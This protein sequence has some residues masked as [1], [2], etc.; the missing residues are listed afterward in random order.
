M[1]VIQIRGVSDGAHRRLKEM[2][3]GEGLSLT[4]FLR[5]ELEEMARAMTPSEWSEWVA[6]REPVTG[7]S[8]AEL[9]RQAREE[10][11]RYLDDRP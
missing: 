6:S 1:G 8:G 7:V 11:E 9:V 3:A 2:A 5:E 4:E 10:R